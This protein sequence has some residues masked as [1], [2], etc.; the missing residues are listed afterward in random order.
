MKGIDLTLLCISMTLVCTIP[1][2][3]LFMTASNG[4]MG[5]TIGWL[6]FMEFL[7]PT[8]IIGLALTIHFVHKV[9]TT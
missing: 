1:M 3:I 7:T 9:Q 2:L 8:L 4:Q 6:P 5:A